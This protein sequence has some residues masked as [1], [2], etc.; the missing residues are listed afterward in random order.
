[1]TTRKLIK[2]SLD[3]TA[4]AAPRNKVG[5]HAARMGQGRGL[6]GRPEGWRPQVRPWRR[7]EDN[8]GIT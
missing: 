4:L 1:M 2:A 7:W 8:V 3:V 6:V 5:G